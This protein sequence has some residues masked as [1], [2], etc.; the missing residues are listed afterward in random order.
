MRPEIVYISEELKKKVADPNY[1]IKHTKKDPH[2]GQLQTIL[3]PY[4]KRF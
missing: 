4:G 3:V 2:T 1:E